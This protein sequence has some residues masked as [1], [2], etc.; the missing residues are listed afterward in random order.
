MK[1]LVYF[2]SPLYEPKGTPIR[3]R[4][5]L[6][7]LL[8]TGFTVYYAGQDVPEQIPAARVLKLARPFARIFQ[9]IGFV[10]RERIDI[11]YLQTSAAMWLVPFLFFFTRSALGVDFHNRIYQEGR[12]YHNYSKFGTALRESLE[13]LVCRLLSFGTAVSMTLRD[14]YLPS[15]PRL[16]VLPVGVD[17]TRF[18][19]EVT[20]R[21]DIIEWKGKTTLIAYAGNLK[22][23]QGLDTVLDAYKEAI[24]RHPG[25]YSFLIIGSSSSDD[26]AAFIAEHGLDERVRIIGKQPHEEIPSYLA[27]ADILTV[28]R[29]SDIIT[30]YAFPSKFS[31]YTALGKALVVSRVSD[32][33]NYIQDG[34]N[35]IL[36]E[37]DDVRGTSVAFERLSDPELRRAIGRKARSLALAEFDLT[38]LGRKLKEFLDAIPAR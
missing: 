23:Y 22:W 28:V 14:F 1:I 11:V 29:P 16:L 15:V 31:E 25:T 10:R 5:I 32:L 21:P 20:P 8:D 33:G 30:E 7:Q 26:Q 34:E 19:P 24:E 27:A 36:V 37:P 12:F 2:A 4:N 3:T 9:L 13:L 35:G 38:L 18:S 6:K 17:T